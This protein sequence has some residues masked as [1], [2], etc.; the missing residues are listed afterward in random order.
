MARKTAAALSNALPIAEYVYNQPEISEESRVGLHHL[1][2]DL[3]AGANFAW[4]TVHNHML[5]CRSMALDNLSKTI[6]PI[7]LDQKVALLHA[8]FK[9]TTFFGGELAKLHRPNKEHASS[10]TVYPAASPQ[11]YSTVPYPGRGRSFRK[12]CSSYRRSGRDRDQSRSTPSS[13]VTRPS[14]SGNGQSTMTVTV[15]KTRTDVRFRAMRVLPIVKDTVNRGSLAVTRKNEGV[16]QHNQCQ[17]G[18]YYASLC[19]VEAYNERSLCVKHC[20]QGVQTSF[21]ESTPSAPDPLENSIPQRVTEDSGNA[22]A[23]FPNLSKER[24]LRDISRYSRVLLECI[25]GSQG[26]WRVASSYI[27]K[28]TEPPQRHSSLSHAH[29]KLSVE[30]RRRLRVQNRFAGCVL[31]C[32]NTSGQQEVPTFCLRKQGISVSSTSLWSEPCPSGI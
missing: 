8:P 12:G 18:D 10:V 30:Y 24:N 7:D 14:R 25:S 17:W 15:N 16:L 31:S 4:R 19:G 5:M 23:N 21:Y 1:K 22:R 11:S 29:H 28:T 6:P 32:T 26:V 3:V 27:L 2:L 20:N 13:T 9:G